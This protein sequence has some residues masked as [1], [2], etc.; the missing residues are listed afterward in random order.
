MSQTLILILTILVKT[1][2]TEYSRMNQVRFVEDS[3]Y[4]IW[5]GM[6]C[7]KHTIPLQI[8]KRL[9]STNFV[10]SIVLEYFF[11]FDLMMKRMVRLIINKM[12]NSSNIFSSSKFS[13]CFYNLLLL[14][15]KVKNSRQLNTT[16]FQ[17][18]RR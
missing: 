1:F 17:R 13:T 6:V 8:F 11:P 3:L 15:R 4:K 18:Y 9:S 14:Y 10:W 7:I 16:T 12:D 5:R 2:G